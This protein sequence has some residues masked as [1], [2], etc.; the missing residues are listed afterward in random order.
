MHSVIALTTRDLCSA[1]LES[2]QNDLRGLNIVTA[3]LLEHPL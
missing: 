2:G 1:A 3:Y